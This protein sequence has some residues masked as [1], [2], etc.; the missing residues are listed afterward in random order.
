MTPAPLF[1][2]PAFDERDI[3]RSTSGTHTLEAGRRYQREAR[4][5][6][7]AIGDRGRR[8]EGE[9]AGTA[10]RPYR[11]SI[12]AEPVPYGGGIWFTSMCSCPVGSQCKHVAAVLFQL[13][14][15]EGGAPARLTPELVRWLSEFERAVK[16]DGVNGPG[17]AP[18][19]GSSR[20][21]LL[22][23]IDLG[24]C[25]SERGTP[26]VYP[27]TV[28]L[29]QQGQIEGKPKGYDTK[30]V[31]GRA[32]AQY[33]DP[34]DVAI[35]SQLAVTRRVDYHGRACA[36]WRRGRRSVRPDRRDRSRA[37]AVA[38]HAAAA[39]G[40]RAHGDAPLAAA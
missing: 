35:L 3:A 32:P 9:V 29:D 28:K 18:R 31:V 26:V 30:N 7:V 33:L 1:P 5:R 40:G 34:A 25:G 24:F 15:D 27:V 12:I 39:H 16:R 36:R 10:S 21:C 8:I 38:R 13:L 6:I 2:L 37:L 11:Q 22:Y 23:R 19:A 4:A 17:K 20:Q 14:A